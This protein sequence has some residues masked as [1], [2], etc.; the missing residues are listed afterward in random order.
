MST[1]S[2]S[3][4]VTLVGPRPYVSGT[5][6]TSPTA[7][8]ISQVPSA[9]GPV[10]DGDGA[11]VR[12]G[13]DAELEPV[14]PGRPSAVDASELSEEHDVSAASTHTATAAG[15]TAIDVLLRIMNAIEPSP[16][17]LPPCRVRPRKALRHRHK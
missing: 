4:A 3:I 17:D 15:A 6:T 1:L 7:T 16:A 10:G 9:H 14:P 5:V 8:L 11:A 12:V 13:A 2:A